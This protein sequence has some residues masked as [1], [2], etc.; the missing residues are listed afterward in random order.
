MSHIYLTQKFVTLITIS[1]L[2]TGC[3]SISGD[4]T[5][6]LSK[7]ESDPDGAKCQVINSV[8]VKRDITTP[9][10]LF[11]QPKYDPINI[12]CEK[13]GYKRSS[14]VIDTTLVDAVYGNI[15]FG[16]LIGVAIDHS[17]GQNRKYPPLIKVFLEPEVFANDEERRAFEDKRNAWRTAA[18]D[19]LDQVHSTSKISSTAGK[20]KPSTNSAELS[21]TNIAIAAW[22]Q[23]DEARFSVKGPRYS[24]K[25]ANLMH[26]S[27]RQATSGN[28][29]ILN[30]RDA[31]DINFESDSHPVSRSLCSRTNADVIY[32]SVLEVTSE[33]GTAG[34]YPDATYYVYNCK[35]NHMEFKS[36][37]LDLDR[38]DKKSFLYQRGLQDTFSEFLASKSVN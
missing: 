33:G 7:I 36:Y 16:G 18:L 10:D 14:D 19:G 24:N 35:S 1:T 31:K 26:D 27:L 13:E 37:T 2:F 22:G 23:V 28:I 29:D 6:R 32:A 20:P 9:A 8:N 38:Q 11:L 21:K 5:S 12:S 15:L 17:S 34:H 25:I 3:A 30:W 4:D